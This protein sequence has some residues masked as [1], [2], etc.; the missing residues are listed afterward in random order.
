MLVASHGTSRPH[1]HPLSSVPLPCHFEVHYSDVRRVR[2]YPHQIILA[3]SGEVEMDKIK[4]V[5]TNVRKLKVCS[6]GPRHMFLVARSRRMVHLDQ[7][8]M[9]TSAARAR[10]AHVHLSFVRVATARY[11]D[12]S[13]NE[14]WF[15]LSCSS[16]V[17]HSPRP[18]NSKKFTTWKLPTATVAFSQKPIRSGAKAHATTFSVPA[19]LCRPTRAVLACIHH[20]VSE[21][22]ADLPSPVK[23]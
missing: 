14:M 1:C 17:A 22:I 4:T 23:R 11:A 16:R 6:P 7:S 18:Q 10:R 21:I 3:F 2:S 9:S 20:I 15:V 12:S 8:G 19:T 5:T 13:G